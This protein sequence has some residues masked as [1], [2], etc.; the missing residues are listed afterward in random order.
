SE[1]VPGRINVPIVTHTTVTTHPS[2]HNKH[3]RTPW[4]AKR[5]TS[6]ACLRGVALVDD[7]DGSRGVLAFV[8]DHPPEHS[9]ARVNDGL[10]HPR[11]S[12]TD[13]AHVTNDDGLTLIYDL[14]A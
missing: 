2:C 7:L 10:C 3:V 9:P 12:Q 6:A 4:A 8:L 1:D 5:S 13:A 11:L 14:A